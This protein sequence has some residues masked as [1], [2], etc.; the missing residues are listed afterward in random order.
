MS[1]ARSEENMDTK[2]TVTPINPIFR[3]VWQMI[4]LM[5]LVFTVAI[6]LLV[7]ISWRSADRISPIHDHLVLQKKLQNLYDLSQ[8]YV[9][10]KQNSPVE[11]DKKRLKLAGLLEVILQSQEVMD[12]KSID[13][14]KKIH[15]GISSYQD[16]RNVRYEKIRQDI[17][18]VL[19]SEIEIHANLLEAVARDTR[20][21]FELVLIVSVVFP[22]LVVFML[23][24]LRNKILHPLDNLRGFMTLLAERDY[25]KMPM[26]G[27]DPLLQPLFSNYNHMVT[28]L[29][30]L[31]E[32]HRSKQQDLEQEIRNA[33]H[34]LLEQ[35]RTL[36][37]AERLAALGEFA[38]GLAHELRNPL[39]GIQMALL[40]LTEDLSDQSHQERLTLVTEE[41]TRTIKIL[42][43]VLDQSK[44]APELP[45]DFSVNEMM[46]SVLQLARYQFPT[47]ISFYCDM[48][49]GLRCCLPEGTLRQALL[50]IVIN[51][52]QAIGEKH[53]A[54]KASVVLSEKILAITVCDNG[55]GFPI[56]LLNASLLPFVTK[57]KAG[58]GLGL[59]M[60][61]R[62][63]RNIGGEMNLRNQLPNGACVTL[64]LPC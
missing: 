56:E 32:S 25:R 15:A 64:K 27:I 35:Q 38:A 4:F 46:A 24:L 48:P 58:T 33:T 3:P 21:E 30:D 19:D 8:E 6:V 14:L 54:V 51:A 62:F 49:E 55:P 18:F 44:H 16:T 20:F 31:E 36:A 34:V 59:A 12:P 28:R 43:N 2:V 17:K 23:Y 60:V 42:N 9:D 52:A 63:V 40:N 57:R 61:N 39:A 37:Q 11:Q 7:A 13:S 53:G 45:M 26:S 10:E 1:E 22:A 41:L 5:S 47:S 29:F 50:N